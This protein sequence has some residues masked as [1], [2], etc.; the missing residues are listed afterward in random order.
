MATR[1]AALLTCTTFIVTEIN[2]VVAAL[3]GHVRSPAH[4]TGVRPLSGVTSLSCDTDHP[5]SLVVDRARLSTE[6]CDFHGV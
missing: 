5:F 1:N 3:P 4:Q 6:A 2:C